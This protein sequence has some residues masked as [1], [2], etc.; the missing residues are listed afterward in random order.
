[1]FLDIMQIL[2]GSKAENQI[3][4]W[5]NIAPPFDKKNRF[6]IAEFVKN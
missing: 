4:F 2:L 6:L 3:T 5:R 1:M